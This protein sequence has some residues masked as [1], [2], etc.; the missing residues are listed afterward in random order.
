VRRCSTTAT[1]HSRPSR[2]PT[3]RPS[4]SRWAQRICRAKKQFK[5]DPLV[6]D[7]HLAKLL[8]PPTFR[9]SEV[10]ITVRRIPP[11][12][13]TCIAAPIRIPLNA[14]ERR[15]MRP[16][17]RPPGVVSWLRPLSRRRASPTGSE[18]TRTYGITF[19]EQRQR[20][21]VTSNGHHPPGLLALPGPWRRHRVRFFRWL[22]IGNA[23]GKIGCRGKAPEA[24]LDCS[25]TVCS[26]LCVRVRSS[27]DYF[28]SGYNSWARFGFGGRDRERPSHCDQFYANHYSS[29]I[30]GDDCL[31]WSLC[32]MEAACHQ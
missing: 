22:V 14:D 11:T 7:C 23:C 12:F 13:V 10:W 15:R 2:S 30:W 21:W 17:M 27:S 19:W 5:H 3:H 28:C 32:D 1:P 8:K 9:F 26:G 25:T 24:T 18:T 29:S 4:G 31:F 16:K 6:R 20:R